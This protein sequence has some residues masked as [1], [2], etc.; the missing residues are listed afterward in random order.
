MA[1][2]AAEV[3]RDCFRKWPANLARHGVLVTSFAE[4]ILFDGFATHEH[5]LLVERRTP[6]TVGARIV[7]IAY[8]HI[9]A[10]K[11]V[12]VVKMIAFEPMGFVMPAA[13]KTKA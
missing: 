6:D 13:P 10:V 12:D 3:W 7:L 11:I 4:Q 9:Q 5:L 8:Q 2:D 1:T